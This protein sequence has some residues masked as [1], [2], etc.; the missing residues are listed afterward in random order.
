[1]A[2]YKPVS[3]TESA[4]HCYQHRDAAAVAVCRTCG[5]DV[6]PAC[7]HEGEEGIT[8]SDACQALAKRV[9]DMNQKAL[10]IYG[11]GEKPRRISVGLVV[12]TFPG[13]LFAI[14]GGVSSWR[15]GGVDA[16]DAFALT[17]GTALVLIGVWL[18]YQ[19]IMLNRKSN[20]TTS[21]PSSC[22]PT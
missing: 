18:H 20:L 15:S 8:C 1:L 4:T 11:I 3:S 22:S 13:P 7:A 19:Q 16:A 17:L 14:F 10:R 5:R 6:C 9:H 21:S 2:V 12:W